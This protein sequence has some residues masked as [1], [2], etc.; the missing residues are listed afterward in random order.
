MIRRIYCAFLETLKSRR[1]SREYYSFLMLISVGPKVAIPSLPDKRVEA[2][3]NIGLMCM[4]VQGDPPVTFV[5]TKDGRSVEGVPD[6]IVDS[7]AVA[8]SIFL[9][10]AHKAHTGNYTCVASN[11]VGY[12]VATTEILVDGNRKC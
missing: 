6:V 9:T 12:S 5:W 1:S 2:G 10:R 11:L 4:L 3:A 8:S 7:K